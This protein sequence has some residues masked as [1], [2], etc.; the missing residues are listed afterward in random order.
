MN[1]DEYHNLTPENQKK[2][3]NELRAKR[4]EMEKYLNDLE[5][6]QN[7]INNLYETIDYEKKNLNTKK[8]EIQIRNKKLK[9]L[10]DTYKSITNYNNNFSRAGMALSNILESSFDK[11]MN[12]MFN[13]V[14]DV[15]KK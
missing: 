6:K 12:K 7:I 14:Y 9:E 3:L 8:K 5:Y 2:Y 15:T 10:D 4:N 13:E 1:N 11:L